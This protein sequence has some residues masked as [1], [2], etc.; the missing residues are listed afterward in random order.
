[1]NFTPPEVPSLDGAYQLLE[2]TGTVRPEFDRRAGAYK[3]AYEEYNRSSYAFIANQAVFAANRSEGN[4]AHLA[5]SVVDLATKFC[6]AEQNLTELATEHGK[7]L[8]NND[9]HPKVLKLLQR[10]S[11]AHT[12]FNRNRTCP[13]LNLGLDEA[14]AELANW[15]RQAQRA[16]DDHAG[17]LTIH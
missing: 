14:L 6:E 9:S 1:M 16:L 12:T 8:S 13:E 2:Q 15:I 10:L 5:S 3:K 11:A 17:A 4:A 7:L